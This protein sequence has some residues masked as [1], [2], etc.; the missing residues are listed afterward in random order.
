[1][2]EGYIR[3]K[4]CGCQKGRD[5]EENNLQKENCENEEA[6]EKQSKPQNSLAEEGKNSMI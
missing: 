4:R 6:P 3:I 5:T 1:M 2:E